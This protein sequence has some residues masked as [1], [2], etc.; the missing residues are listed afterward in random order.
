M[1]LKVIPY[2]WLL[3]G[4]NLLGLPVKTDHTRAMNIERALQLIGPKPE[5]GGPQ[6]LETHSVEQ[7]HVPA[8]DQYQC[9][10]WV[11][12]AWSSLPWAGLQTEHKP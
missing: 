3:L 5:G 2:W 9:S 1:A 7:L 4:T 6:L 8:G 11:E 12:F 10:A